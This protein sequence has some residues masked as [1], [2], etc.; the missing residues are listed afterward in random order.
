M[1]HPAL[2]F[3]LLPASAFA[4]GADPATLLMT[5]W[6]V[7][8]IVG[9]LAFLFLSSR[10][11]FVKLQALA[12]L[13]AATAVAWAALGSIQ[14]DINSWQSAVITIVLSAAPLLGF[15][16]VLFLHRK[17]ANAT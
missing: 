1:K 13:L 9:V 8:L 5:W 4:H 2:W 12:G 14:S 17:R 7:G 10:R 15:L 3:G 11:A 16:S 6:Y